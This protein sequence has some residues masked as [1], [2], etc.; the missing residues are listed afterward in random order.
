MRKIHAGFIVAG[1]L[2]YSFSGCAMFRPINYSIAFKNTGN[3]KIWVYPT[4]V[5]KQ[6]LG[7][8]VL[9]PSAR[10][11]SSD[12]KLVP[13]QVNVKWKNGREE[14]IEKT[15]EVKKN[16]PRRFRSDRDC[17]I[18][19]IDDDDNVIM[20]FSIKVGKYKWEDIDSEGNKVD[21][22]QGKDR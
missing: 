16:I 21:F 11:V 12:F 22:G 1:L 3:E 9:V 20:T 17:I 4:L 14:I 19:N 15:V 13:E 8:G 18:F 10:S 2:I 6:R 5:G 7:A